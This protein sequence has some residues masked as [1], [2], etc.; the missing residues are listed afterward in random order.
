M[1]R[2][3]SIS[4]VLPDDARAEPSLKPSR[5]PSSRQLSR[6]KSIQF[7]Y[8]APKNL[9]RT[10]SRRMSVKIDVKNGSTIVAK[11]LGSR[12]SSGLGGM[13]RQATIG[14]L[15]SRNLTAVLGEDGLHSG[16]SAPERSDS[17]LVRREGKMVTRHVTSKE[18]KPERR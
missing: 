5:Q 16:A 3:R 14:R 9:S 4:F 13:L 8:Q 18:P 10:L 11:E 12:R 6:G 7:Q 15:S 17:S 1:S 2:A